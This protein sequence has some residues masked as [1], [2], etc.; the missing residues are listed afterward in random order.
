MAK[1]R[2]QCNAQLGGAVHCHPNVLIG[3]KVC[4]ASRP[5]QP[6]FLAL[7]RRKVEMC[8]SRKVGRSCRVEISWKVVISST[9]TIIRAKYE[10]ICYIITKYS[11]I[12]INTRF[13]YLKFDKSLPTFGTL[14]LSIINLLRNTVQLK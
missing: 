11:K 3:W 8:L 6:L 7:A 9:W 13:N 12:E 14:T 10:A 1:P 5:T 2:R 4:S